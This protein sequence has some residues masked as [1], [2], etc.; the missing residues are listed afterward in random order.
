M[1]A[2]GAAQKRRLMIDVGG[3]AD[4]ASPVAA[5]CEDRPRQTSTLRDW[6]DGSPPPEAALAS[7][8][9]GA[10]MICTAVT[11]SPTGRVV[12]TAGRGK[13]AAVGSRA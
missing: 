1:R 8:R 7:T 9:A 5:A 6:P 11:A 10:A 3:R 4:E 2:A 12:S 13:G